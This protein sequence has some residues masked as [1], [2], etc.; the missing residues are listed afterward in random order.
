MRLRGQGGLLW[1]SLPV[2]Q[3]L[4]RFVGKGWNQFYGWMLDRQEKR[5]TMAALLKRAQKIKSE[6]RDKGLYDLSRGDYHARYL[7]RHGLESGQTVLDFG[8]GFGRTG[9]PLIR[10]LEPERYI[11]VEISRERLRLAEEWTDLE[12]LQ[13]KRPRWLLE[14]D[15]T[16]PYLDDDSIDV[17]WAQSVLT[18]MPRREVEIF[19]RAARRALRPGGIMLFNFTISEDGATHRSNVKDYRY[20]P[21]RI[22]SLC[23]AEGFSYEQLDDWQ[24]DLDEDARATHNHMIKAAKPNLSAVKR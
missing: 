18:H 6:R 19:V 10:Y 12:G 11:G 7:Q 4:F 17:I 21:E 20:P 22:E 2:V 15:N 8:C 16:L 3:V 23:I 5:N 9:I 14:F 24:D 1:K 13:D